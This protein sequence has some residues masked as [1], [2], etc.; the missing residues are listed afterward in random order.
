MN[1]SE[2]NFQEKIHTGY[3]TVAKKKKFYVR[4]A[5]TIS[6]ESAQRMSEILFLL[7]EHKIH[8]F[9]LTRNFL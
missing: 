7:L 3:Y 2:Y 8:F 1:M 5:R 4:V 9:E 6:Y